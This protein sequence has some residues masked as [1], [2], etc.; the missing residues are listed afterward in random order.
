LE[1]GLKQKLN[2]VQNTTLLYSL[3][4]KIWHFDELFVGLPGRIIYW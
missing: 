2:F 1:E 4:D 3:H